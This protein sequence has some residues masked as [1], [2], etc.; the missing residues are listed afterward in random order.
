MQPT[1]LP[2][3][4]LFLALLLLAAYGVLLYVRHLERTRPQ[5]LPW[6]PLDLAAPIGL[7]TGFKLQRL[8]DD[9]GACRDALT[10]AGVAYT[11]MREQRTGPECGFIDSLV[12]D[13]SSVA[14][15]PTP[16]RISCPVAAA[17]VI[18]ERR[19]VA[20]AAR[21][22]LGTEITGVRHYG[23]YSC[24]RLYGRDSGPWSE[25]ATANAIDIAG[26]TTADGRELSVL[27]DWS[28]PTDES[29]FLRAAH[30]GA[31]ELFGTTLGPDYN[32]AHRDH[33]HFDMKGWR[34]CR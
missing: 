9:P 25:H 14:Y 5:D 17:L 3:L 20:P 33:F 18:W 19:V 4:A 22:I 21:H 32:A 15:A 29:A 2:R 13:R 26:F 10:R 11:P 16:V 30:H 34:T 12:L 27:D 24:R 31:C 28:D 7:A 8:R 23:T 6:T 1:R